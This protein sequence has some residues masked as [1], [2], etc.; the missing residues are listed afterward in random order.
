MRYTQDAVLLASL[1]LGRYL[2]EEEKAL[3]LISIESLAVCLRE[4]K[5]YLQLYGESFKAA[6]IGSE[7]VSIAWRIMREYHSVK[8]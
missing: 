3:S 2:Q 7:S 8:E 5:S 6:T 1:T 4:D